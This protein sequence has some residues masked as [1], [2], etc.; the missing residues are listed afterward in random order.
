MQTNNIFSIANQYDF[1][2]LASSAY[3]IMLALANATGT[4]LNGRFAF[5]DFLL[6]IAVAMPLAINRN[7]FYQFF[8]FT[9]VLLW[10]VVGFFI[11]LRMHAMN[12]VDFLVGSGLSLSAIASGLLMI[13][14]GM[15]PKPH[16]H[17]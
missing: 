9:N 10:L 1:T 8:G 12:T 13:H 3:F 5:F 4:L 2:K 16:P 14:S 11:L 7:W 6:L 17:R 15:Y